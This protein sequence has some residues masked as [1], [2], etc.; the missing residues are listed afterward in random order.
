MFSAPEAVQEAAPVAA[1][2]AA[3]PVA[4]SG[5]I[6]H[7]PAGHLELNFG[8]VDLN[9]W[10]LGELGVAAILFGIVLGLN[11]GNSHELK[12]TQ[13]SIAGLSGFVGVMGVLAHAVGV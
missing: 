8:V 13:G 1:A 5:F 11:A 9:N 12:G 6:T 10:T 2:P 3:T 4:E 7:D